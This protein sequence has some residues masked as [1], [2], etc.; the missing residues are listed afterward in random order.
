MG[1]GWKNFEVQARKSLDCL[2]ETIGGNVDVTDDSG[3]GSEGSEKNGRQVSI[4][5]ENTCI[6]I[7][8][9]S[10]EMLKGLW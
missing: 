8:R 4:I 6:I 2:E 1:R 3:M 5:L 9:T 7:E 10:A